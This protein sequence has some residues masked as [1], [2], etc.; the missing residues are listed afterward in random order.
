MKVFGIGLNKT[1]T[2]TLAQCFKRFGFMHKSFDYE[3]LKISKSGNLRSLLKTINDFESFEDW[4][5]P[6]YYQYLDAA[7]PGSKFVLT[8]RISS[9]I[10]LESLM[11]HSLKANPEKGIVSRTLVYNY[12]YPHCNPSYFM[13]FYNQHILE[14]RNY[15]KGRNND[16]LEVC[17]EEQ[18]D[19]SN[20]CK[21][22]NIEPISDPFPHA[23]KAPTGNPEIMSINKRILAELGYQV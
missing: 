16:F 23:N 8:R 13:H 4:P 12:P 15:F 3:L 9:D 20:L 10:W 5:Y 14:V 6:L 18:S 1:G 7:F 21:F 11:N 2:K 22:L 17:W 19:W